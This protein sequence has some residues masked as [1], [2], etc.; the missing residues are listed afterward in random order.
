MHSK[1]NILNALLRKALC[2]FF[3]LF[4]SISFSI[5]GALAN[6]CNGGPDCLNCAQL[7]HLHVSGVEAD[8]ENHGCWPVESNGSC[9]VE[10]SQNPDEFHGIVPVI[11]TE[12][13]EYSG[14]FR[15]APGEHAQSHL[16]GELL[17]QF[18]SHGSVKITPIYLLNH[19]LLC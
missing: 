8:M 12:K 14:I 6:G 13:H 18:R 11:R 5:G 3:I 16:S 15:D 7:V 1:L 2:F 10:T 19:S 4:I 9:G 17:S